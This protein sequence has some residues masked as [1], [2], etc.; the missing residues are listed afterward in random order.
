L[1]SKHNYGL[2][3][4][5]GQ[6]GV[7][8]SY[9]GVYNSVYKGVYSMPGYKIDYE[10]FIKAWNEAHDEGMSQGELAKKLGIDRDLVVS[11]RMKLKK[12]GVLLPD[13]ANGHRITPYQLRQLQTAAHKPATSPPS[14]AKRQ[15]PKGVA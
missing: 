8:K 7:D 6:I 10:S 9:S 13:L 11:R 15:P 2:N 14:G 5:C 3:N 4:A 1:L 12:V